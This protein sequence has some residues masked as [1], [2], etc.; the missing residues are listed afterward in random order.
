MHTCVQSHISLHG[1]TTR[2]LLFIN[3]KWNLLSN[4]EWNQR[5]MVWYSCG[6]SVSVIDQ[7]DIPPQTVGS[8][9]YLR[10]SIT[11]IITFTAVREFQT[12]RHCRSKWR[13]YVKRRRNVIQ[14]RIW[15]A[16]AR[17]QLFCHRVD[18]FY[19]RL[20]FW[21]RL[22]Q[23]AASIRFENWGVV[24]R[25]QFLNPDDRRVWKLG[26]ASPKSSRNGGA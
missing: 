14:L 26:V 9:D 2:D 20:V 5:L 24:P 7:T 8:G 12:L 15:P 3:F 22:S 4:L 13:I 21:M 17:C 16:P 10:L 25:P 19:K 11:I 6:W 18:L 23:T 1:P